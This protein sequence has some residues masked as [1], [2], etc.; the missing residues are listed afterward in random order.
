MT[1][2][3]Q[4]SASRDTTDV[5]RLQEALEKMIP[6]SLSDI[7]R[8]NTDRFAIGLATVDEI[9]AL[10]GSIEPRRAKDTIDEW[11]VI[12]FR[13]LNLQAN[14]D[15]GSGAANSQLSLLGH[16]VGMS[17]TWITSEVVRIDFDN[18]LVQTRNSLYH[19]GAKGIGEP[20]Q[21]DLIQVCAATYA[22]GFG[23]LVGAPM[24]FF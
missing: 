21:H 5:I 2:N 24:F 18:S 16:S 19:L 12:A 17:S 20:P 23:E 10:A 7:V 3:R 4:R 15:H 22:W 8:A 1:D 13:T 9:A 14:V 11:R 6:R